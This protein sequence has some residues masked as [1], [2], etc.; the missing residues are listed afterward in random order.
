MTKTGQEGD[1]APVQD[2]ACTGHFSP[3]TK[4]FLRPGQNSV[5]KI[6]WTRAYFERG[7]KITK[8]GAVRGYFHLSENEKPPKAWA[9]FILK[10]DWT[11]EGLAQNN[12]RLWQNLIIIIYLTCL[13]GTAIQLTQTVIQDRGKVRL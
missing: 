4:I 7:H 2:R 9:I 5:L 1:D 12:P 11:G 10:I 3:L 8:T 6:D 13:T